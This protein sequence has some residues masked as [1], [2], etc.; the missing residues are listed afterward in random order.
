MPLAVETELDD[1]TFRLLLAGAAVVLAALSTELVERP[2]RRSSLLD[3]RPRFS[4]EMGLAGSV[5]VGVAGLFM[6][7]AVALPSNISVPALQP[8][9]VVVE[10]TGVRE[11]LP[12]PFADECHI[13]DW[14]VKKLQ[15]DCVYG[16]P[17]GEQTAMLIGDSHG[18][19][20][21]PA[22]NRY[23][24]DQGWRLE[25]H[26]KGGCPVIDVPVF[27]RDIRR[28]YA[29]CG[30]WR[31]R[32]GRHISKSQPEVVFVGLSRDYELWS[33]GQ[34]IQSSTARTYWKEK[35]TELLDTL[36]ADAGRVILLAETPTFN[37]DPVNCLSSPDN[38]D[39]DGPAFRVLDSGYAALE[40][41]ATEATG[42]ELFSINELLCSATT[43]PVVV[44]G[45][46]VYRDE[47]H[48]TAS[49]MEQLATP[50]GRMLDG[51]SPYPSPSPSPPPVAAAS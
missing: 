16:D 28:E 12:A 39:C 48:V 13:A 43:C 8:D 25:V 20:W 46:P 30:D 31:E 24:Q 35:L 5:A 27:K 26:T 9:P 21:Q 1:L 18:V 42:V 37:Y 2:F 36:A 44:D 17:E 4:L 19:M 32:L 51:K 38:N 41:A 34:V 47:D 6:S 45:M 29:E 22:L 40:R 10:L 33:G 11:D 15:R 49:Y 50:I 14:R 7:G 3:R 23:A